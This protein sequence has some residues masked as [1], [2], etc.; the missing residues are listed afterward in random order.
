M[1]FAPDELDWA[2]ELRLAI[3]GRSALSPDAL[4]GLEAN[5]RFGDRETMQS[6]IFGRLSAWQNWIFIRPERSGPD[7]RAEG[8][9]HRETA[10]NSIGSVSNMA[11]VTEGRSKRSIIPSAFRT[12]SIWRA[13]ERLQRALEHWQPAFL[14]WWKG[15]GPVDTSKLR[16]LSADRDQRGQRRLGELRLRAHAGISLGHFPDAARRKPSDQLRRSQGRAGLAGRSRANTAPRC[17]ASSS[18]RATPNPRRSSSS[19]CWA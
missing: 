17:G 18:R 3:E 4:T 19:A 13:I 6:R 8:L 9:R 14:D 2:D 15:T 12:T 5:L 16:S 1:T 10:P 7:R 11:E